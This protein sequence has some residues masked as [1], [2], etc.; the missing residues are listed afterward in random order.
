VLVVGLGGN[1]L[2]EPDGED[3]VEAD[4]ARTAATAKQL[5]ALAARGWRL[6]II[7]GNG[8]QVGNHLLR[9]ELGHVH[10]GLPDL[11]LD[12]CVA[13]TQGGMGYMVQQCL[14]NELT[15]A[16]LPAVVATVV[17]QVLVDRND[18][19]FRNPSK[20]V[21]EIIPPERAGA[22]REAGWDLVEDGR[23]KG[24]RRVVA[25]PLPT[26]IVEAAA[27]KAMVDDGIVVIACGG[28][29]VA[30]AEHEDG[31]LHG[32]SAVVD[33]DFAAALLATDLG[34]QALLVLTNVSGVALGYGTSEE[35]LISRMTVADARSYR[36]AGEFEAGSMGP[37]VEAVCRFVEA[38][39]RVGVITSIDQG[40][41]AF[42]HSLGTRI[43]P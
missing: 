17:T 37:K 1:A 2:Q 5:A 30:V 33:K 23:R 31:R 28:G 4:F 38:T 36:D 29:G 41:R 26:E 14:I 24:F 34:A 19:A 43:V 22:L 16:D 13:D 7:H 11:P 18:P 35:S 42:T 10:G 25:S 20:P 6:V 12:V 9:S 39:G 21:G 8:P 3:S 32:V 40:A 15:E 27:I